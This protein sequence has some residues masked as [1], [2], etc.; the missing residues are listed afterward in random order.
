M[1]KG[2][3]TQAPKKR[4]SGTKVVVGSS[5]TVRTGTAKG[6]LPRVGGGGK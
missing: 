6:K 5:S 4:G 2:N 1:K 3:A